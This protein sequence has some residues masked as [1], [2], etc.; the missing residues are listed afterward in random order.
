MIITNA[1]IVL[2]HEV[3]NGTVHIQDGLIKEI[4]QGNSMLPEA[5]NLDGDI[6]IPG[7]VELHTDNFERHL[8]PRP[9][10]RWAELPALIAHDVELIG[11]GITTVFDSI[12][13]G[14]ADSKSVRGM[15]FDAVMHALHFSIENQLLKSDHFIHIRCELPAPNTVELFQAFANDDRLR[16]ISLMD[17]TPGQRQFEDISQ[18]RNYYT[19]KKG[20]THSFF[21][22][23]VAAG[24]DL[25]ERYAK[26]NRQYF[27]D[28]CK[29]HQ[30]AMASHDDTT[31]EHVQQAIDEG[32]S[33]CEFPT[34]LNAAQ[35]AHQNHLAV[36]MGAPNL[37]RGGS[38]SGNV[39]AKDLAL[40]GHLDILSSD[41][42]P[43]SLLSAAFKLT[44]V[45]NFSL[46]AAIATVTLQPAKAVGLKDRGQIAPNQIA[47]LVRIR[48]LRNSQRQEFPFVSSVWR[49]GIKVV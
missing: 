9:K 1:K 48:M 38:H 5:I 40:A 19:G 28:F 24:P 26:P 37:V 10:T 29:S 47:D 43:N 31:L 2:A 7:L 42:I 14:E 35:A 27:V 46:P 15:G 22:E 23:R 36:I 12:G 49:A 4:A 41:Y 32:A 6:L 17:H 25:Q 18:A 34:R 20:W 39:A 33:I 45:A 16:L 30:I 11:A 8:M 44:E 21:D 3:I 13:I